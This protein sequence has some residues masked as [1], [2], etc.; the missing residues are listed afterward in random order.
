MKISKSKYRRNPIKTIISNNHN[1]TKMT[2]FIMNRKN[3]L[4][5]IIFKCEFNQ[6]PCN[7]SALHGY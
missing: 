7:K 2:K 5:Y 4:L 3:C 6:P 1:Y